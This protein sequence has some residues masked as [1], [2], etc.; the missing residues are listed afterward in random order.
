MRKPPPRAGGGPARGV[1]M[2]NAGFVDCGGVR[3]GWFAASA[4]RAVLMAM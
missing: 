3:L 4:V 2:L 1:V